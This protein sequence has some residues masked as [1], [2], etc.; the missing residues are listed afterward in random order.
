[1]PRRKYGHMVHELPK[2]TPEKCRLCRLNYPCPVHKNVKIDYEKRAREKRKRYS[3]K[4]GKY[5]NF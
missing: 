2:I 5:A 3:G 4:I 1:M